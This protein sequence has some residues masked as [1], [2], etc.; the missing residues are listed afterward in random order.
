VSQRTHSLQ[1]S[2]PSGHVFH[3][4]TYGGQ[5]STNNPLSLPVTSNMTA[6][7]HY[8]P[9]PYHW[10]TVYAYDIYSNELPAEVYIDGGQLTGMSGDSFN[11]TEGYHTIEVADPVWHQGLEYWFYYFEGYEFQENPVYVPVSS[12]TEVTAWYM[13]I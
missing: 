12:D 10:L 5:T 7:A 11:V 6:T 8:I 4:Y 9:Q 1:V 3:N 13:N 2:V